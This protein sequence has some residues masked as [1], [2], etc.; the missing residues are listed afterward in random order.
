MTL[1]IISILAFYT[2]RGIGAKRIYDG[3]GGG[4]IYKL[5]LLFAYVVAVISETYIFD[6]KWFWLFLI[7][8]PIAFIGGSILGFIYDSISP[9]ANILT[10]ILI[11]IVSMIIGI[12]IV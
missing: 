3:D 12:L 10:P 8:V 11:G 4:L 1:L 9:R 2:S 5:P 7:N 6:M